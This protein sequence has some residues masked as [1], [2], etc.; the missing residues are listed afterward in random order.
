MSL[1][2]RDRDLR[3]KE[4]GLVRRLRIGEVAEFEKVGEGQ[5]N[6]SKRVDTSQRVICVCIQHKRRKNTKVLNHKAVTYPRAM[7]RYTI[8]H[9]RDVSHHSAK[10]RQPGRSGTIKLPEEPA[11]QATG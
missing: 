2:N 4:K 1:R 9:P 8:G 11:Q 10:S 5:Q 3:L 7:L 6:N